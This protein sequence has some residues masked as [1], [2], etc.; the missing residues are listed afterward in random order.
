MLRESRLLF[1]FGLAGHE[2][3][4]D[5]GYEGTWVRHTDSG[6]P[7]GFN[8]TPFTR[9][10]RI[11]FKGPFLWLLARRCLI[12]MASFQASVV[13]L[14]ANL[15]GWPYTHKGMGN[16][17][18]FWRTFILSSL[19]LHIYLILLKFVYTKTILCLYYGY[20]RNLLEHTSLVDPRR[21]LILHTNN[22]INL[23]LKILTSLKYFS[24]KCFDISAFHSKSHYN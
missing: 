17:V 22:S 21:S 15:F 11:C 6:Y 8:F 18:F 23:I 7:T 2:V 20:V 9:C 19:S 12:L 4:M 10:S 16:W 1:N 3:H 24:L 5:S 13:L 14:H